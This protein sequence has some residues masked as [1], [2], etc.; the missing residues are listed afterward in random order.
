MVIIADDDEDMA[1]EDSSDQ[2]L[3]DDTDE[4]EQ[5]SK[6]NT[7]GKREKELHR[8]EVGRVAWQADDVWLAC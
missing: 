3:G 6:L 8:Q 1:V 5:R 7:S 4:K 2:N